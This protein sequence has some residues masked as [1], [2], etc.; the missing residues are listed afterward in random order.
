MSK[1]LV[2]VESPMK[3]R[4]IGRF[5]PRDMRVLAS[6]GHIRDLPESS[7]GVD[8]GDRFNPV[9]VL[10][11]NGQRV[12]KELRKAAEGAEHI[13]LATDPDR[14]GEA[15]A[16]HIREV[17][18]DHT[19]GTFHRVEFHE[20]TRGAIAAAFEAPGALDNNKVA[21][22]QARRVLDRIVG[23]QVSPL[24]WRQIQKGTSAG[25][26]QSVALRLICERERAIQQFV[27]VEYW[28]LNA[29]FQP[30]PVPETFAARLVL[31][32]GKKPEV[33]SADAAN[34]LA[35]QLDAAAFRIVDVVKKPKRQSAPPPFI[36][37]TLQQSA[38]NSLRF[39]AS[40]TMRVAQQLYEGVE[41]G[42]SGPT[43]LITYMRTDSV[44]V[45]QEA[46]TQAREYV[47]ERFGAEY[48]PERP[49]V[50]RSRE[51]AQEAHE[52]I[53]PTDVRRTPDAVAAFL[54]PPQLRLYR[55]IWNRFV[56]SQMAPA[57]ILEHVVDVGAEGA[58]LTHTYLFRATARQTTFAGYLAVYDIKENDT[59]GNPDSDA[60]RLPD[61]PQGTPCLLKKLDREQRFTEPPK[62]YTEAT[63]IRELE[64]NGVGRPSTY[65]TIFDTILGRDYVKNEKRILIPTPLGFAVVDYLVERLPDLFQ[66]EFTASMESRLDEIE[67]GKV[68][69]TQMLKDFYTRFQDWLGEAP[70]PAAP[71]PEN[72]TAFVALFPDT[73]AWQPPEKRGRRTYDDRAF[74]LSLK[75]QLAKGK[76]LSDKQWLALL[77]L[78]ARYAGQIPGLEDTA[79]AL[80]ALPKLQELIT[81][82]QAAAARPAGETTAGVPDPSDMA[83]LDVLSGINW[84][85]PVRRGRRSFNDRK[86]YNSIH[87]QAASGRKLTPAQV[88][89]IKKL[90]AK[91][92]TQ[93]SEFSSVVARFD[94]KTAETGAGG[95]ADQTDVGPLI[96]MID[97]VREWAAPVKR[98]RRVYDD[99]EFAN[100]VR[101][102]FNRRGTLS[103]RQISALRKM[104]SRYREQIP[105]AGGLLQPPP[106]AKTAEPVNANC[107]ECGAQLMRRQ[108]RKGEFFGCSTFPKCRYTATSLPAADAATPAVADPSPPAA[109]PAGPG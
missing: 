5:L 42:E 37:S 80:G 8:V 28:N 13:Y 36:T 78:A 6:M 83:L 38:G 85:P 60:S 95:G 32:D 7:L 100:S 24:L 93:I 9:Y 39:G 84:D 90:V 57:N 72:A 86:F 31:L 18:G 50:Y 62:R 88:D 64:Q 73:I 81:A 41:L 54:S 52:A 30:E 53:R 101:E 71:S 75:E 89:S 74:Y 92:Q 46:Q 77:G 14:E 56:A 104:L 43:G 17:I 91:Y 105:D 79:R 19:K 107:P 47:Q 98:G 12:A 59:N 76:R 68:D 35:T 82:A 1:S 103:D 23:Y 65:A 87:D 27:P 16:W 108:G 58:H 61:V 94:I 63:L 97:S 48:V 40:Q 66:I 49:N 4:T 10:T 3:A 21:A 2:I 22:Q 20:I 69:W 15:I 34:A 26:V 106:K 96:R 51:S 33:P 45:S 44:A 102:Q 11:S 99:R 55:L 109:G 25:R 70:P 67:S 29:L